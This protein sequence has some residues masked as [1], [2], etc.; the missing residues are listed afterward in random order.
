MQAAIVNSRRVCQSSH[1]STQFLMKITRR[2]LHGTGT[3]GTSALG[4]AG[5]VLRFKVQNEFL[6][7]YEVHVVGNITHREYWIPAAELASLNA[8]MT[9]VFETPPLTVSGP[10]Q[11]AENRSAE[12]QPV[13]RST[14]TG[15]VQLPGYG[16]GSNRAKGRVLAGAGDADPVSKRC[17]AAQILRGSRSSETCT[18]REITARI[19]NMWI[20]PPAT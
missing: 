20:N 5:Y 4:F 10:P 16:A 13:A 2:R 6:D 14:A 19:S 11:Q 9:K 1:S 18:I 8:N 17:I 15:R 3:Q 12:I 7:R